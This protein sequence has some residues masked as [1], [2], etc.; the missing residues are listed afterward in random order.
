MSSL[1]N[2]DTDLETLIT[3]YTSNSSNQNVDGDIDTL[4]SDIQTLAT[5]VA[6]LQTLDAFFES[7]LIKA[8]DSIAAIEI[9]INAT[10]PNLDSA[11]TLLADVVENSV[12]DDANDANTSLSGAQGDL[13]TLLATLATQQTTLDGIQAVYDQITAQQA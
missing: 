10:A 2:D 12:F 6:S 13:D 3:N 4:V 5:D 8:R 11:D 1:P 9:L 7:E